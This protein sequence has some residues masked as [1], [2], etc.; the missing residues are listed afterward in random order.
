MNDVPIRREALPP[1]GL[2]GA[3]LAKAIFDAEVP[4]E[5]VAGLSAESL[6]FVLKHNGLNSSADLIEIAP[7]SKCRM[8][9]DFDCWQHDE[10]YE[11]NFFE[12]LALTDVND[13]LRLLE[14]LFQFVDLRLVAL[15]A[16]KYVTYHIF[17]DPTDQPPGPEFYTPDKGHTWMRIHAPDSTKTFLLGRLLALIFERDAGL[18]YELLNASDEHTQ[19]ELMEEAYQ[20]KTR[21]LRAEGIPD[22]AFAHEL[23]SPLPYAQVKAELH[24]SEPHPIVEDIRAIEPLVYGNSIPQPLAGLLAKVGNRDEF[25]AEL[26]LLLNS[27]IVRWSVEFWNYAEVLE[28]AAR[29]KGAINLGLECVLREGGCSDTEAY[30]ILGLQKLYRLGLQRLF[31]LQTEARKIPEDALKSLNSESE[32][33]ALLA[34]LRA[35]FPVLPNCMAAD[36]SI[37]HSADGKLES[38]YRAFENLRDVEH[39]AAALERLAGAGS[40]PSR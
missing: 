26:T 3:R 13:D 30:R 16:A 28:L 14:K 35:A 36:G 33:F 27:G 21:R 8:F 23:H 25:E 2:N 4:E 1:R 38:G 32:A 31:T 20:E 37:R 17:E 5:Y 19:T 24:R 6:Y 10:F 12:W 39:A 40:R 9:L 15:L 7:L 29:V 34:G 22:E 11:D 18:F